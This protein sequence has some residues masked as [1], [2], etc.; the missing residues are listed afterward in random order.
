MPLSS[1]RKA[2]PMSLKRP[3]KALAAYRQKRN[4]STSPEPR[5]EN[6]P[7][8][9]KHR[10]FCVQKHLASH[11]HYDFRLEHHGVL[12][13]WAI[14]K[15]P[16]IDP[17]IKRLAMQVE[18]HPRDYGTFEGVIPSGYGAGIVVLWDRGFWQPLVDDV[19]AALRSGNLPFLLLGEKLAGA[20]TLIRGTRAGPTA[21]LLMKRRDEWSLSSDVTREQ[22]QSVASGGDFSEVL[23][24]APSNP[25]PQD[26]P[27]KSGKI[28][29]LFGKILA[30]AEALRSGAIAN[31]SQAPRNSGRHH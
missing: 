6:K 2:V 13:S 16:S 3:T 31:S 1:P 24:R 26:P 15:G 22:P 19:D 20:W 11:L 10:F 25:W 23:A 5:G 9:A 12:L 27:V 7:K 30:E 28:G 17:S 18:D 8:N 21:W 4:F 14:P 29:A